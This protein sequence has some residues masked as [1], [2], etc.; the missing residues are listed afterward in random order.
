MNVNPESYGRIVSAA[1]LQDNC[2][3]IG[4]KGHHAIFTMEPL[5]VLKSAKQGFVT[6]YGYFVNRE[7]ALYIAEY[8]DQVDTK[9]NPQDKLVSEDLKKR[10][11]KSIKICK[12]LF[13]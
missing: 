2:I 7:T 8:F 12:K 11:L 6:E 9:Y 10:R 5:G 3:Y 1:L 13:I 4:R